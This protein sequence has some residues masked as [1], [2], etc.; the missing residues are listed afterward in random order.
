[1][2]SKS[3]LVVS[4]VTLV[5]VIET[6]DSDLVENLIVMVLPDED[7]V[8]SSS[9]LYRR[10]HHFPHVDIGKNSTAKYDMLL[11]SAIHFLKMVVGIERLNRPRRPTRERRQVDH[12]FM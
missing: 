12:L 3:V 9:L 11:H 7:I 4:F 8:K 1:M 10:E 6:L 5:T 2:F